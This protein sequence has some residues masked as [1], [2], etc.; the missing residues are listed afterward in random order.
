MQHASIQS[1]MR[2][3]RCMIAVWYKNRSSSSLQTAWCQSSCTRTY[4]R[5]TSLKTTTRNSHG[6]FQCSRREQDEF[7]EVCI[8]CC[9]IDLS[10]CQKIVS[11]AIASRYSYLRG[12]KTRL[13]W[14]GQV[15]AVSRIAS[16]PAFSPRIC[17]IGG[18]VRRERPLEGKEWAGVEAT[19]N[20]KA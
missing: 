9:L 8:S 19:G 11:I 6:G 18:A 4:T 7:N 20:K 14:Q 12:A 16:P 3:L 5:H 10:V 17:G 13:H 15:V 1:P 2:T